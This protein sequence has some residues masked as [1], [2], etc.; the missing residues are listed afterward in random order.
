MN[1]NKKY[2]LTFFTS[3]DSCFVSLIIKFNTYIMYS[4]WVCLCSLLPGESLC[5]QTRV[6]LTRVHLQVNKDP[7]HQA[8][9]SL[10][11]GI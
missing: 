8:N 11:F 5:M 2:F 6:N 9:P 1:N 7:C 4:L 10:S 3:L